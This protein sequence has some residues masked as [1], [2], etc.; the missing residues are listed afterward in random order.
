[1]ERMDFAQISFTISV[2]S[3]LLP[4]I[5]SRVILMSR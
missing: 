3:R 4:Y 1:L 5:L 2:I